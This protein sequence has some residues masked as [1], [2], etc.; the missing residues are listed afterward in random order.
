MASVGGRVN[1]ILGGELTREMKSG[2]GS[3]RCL[4]VALRDVVEGRWVQTL[5]GPAGGRGIVG[6]CGPL[7]RSGSTAGVGR[8]SSTRRFF[9]ALLV[10][11]GRAPDLPGVGKTAALEV[12]VV[13][14]P[15]TGEQ[16][17]VVVE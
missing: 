15:C 16:G 14:A 13:V 6:R 5:V 9:V 2:G 8:P 7:H 4:E 10:L 12:H 17:A 1:G 11:G 3:L